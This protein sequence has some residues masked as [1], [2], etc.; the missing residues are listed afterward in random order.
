MTPELLEATLKASMQGTLEALESGEI[1]VPAAMEEIAKT[2]KQTAVV[3]SNMI[4][5]EQE[6]DRKRIV[7]LN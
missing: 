1:D 3:M 2:V 4:L 5:E 7:T 6:K